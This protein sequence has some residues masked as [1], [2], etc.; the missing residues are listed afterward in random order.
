MGEEKAVDYYDEALDRVSLPLEESPWL[1]VYAQAADFLAAGSGPIADV[2]C[3]TGRLARLLWLRGEHD[4]WGIDFSPVRIKE[5]RR[6][7]PEAQFTVGDVYAGH[8][9]ERIRGFYRVVALEI[10]EHIQDD[11]GVIEAMPSGALVVFSVPTY[12]SAAHVRSFDS[13]KEAAHRYAELLDLDPSHAAV[14]PRGRQPDK[15]IFV[16]TGTRH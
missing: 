14:L 2:G 8:V 4:Y 6:Y 16:L 3:G 12:D 13:P 7:V 11:L 5:A 9:R 10:L 15:K 1:G